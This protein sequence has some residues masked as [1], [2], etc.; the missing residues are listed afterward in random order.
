VLRPIYR[1]AGLALVAAALAGCGSDEK[2]NVPSQ[3]AYDDSQALAVESTST[4]LGADG[5]KV[6]DVSFDGPGD[7]RLTGYLVTPSRSSARH[8]AV[9]YG[10]GAGGDRQ[11]L[12]DEAM[13]MAREGAVTLTLDMIYS[14]ARAAPLPEGMAGARENSR[15][16][17]ECVQEVRRA[18]DLLQSLE[19]VDGDQIGYVGWSQGAR[20]GALISGVEHR[21]KAF[22]LIAGGAASVSELVS[23]AP[24]ELQAELTTLFEKTDPIHFV[25][26]AKPS[27]LLF[28]GGRDDDVVPRAAFDALASAGSRPKEV[29][30]YD[31]GHLPTEKMWTD[32]RTWLSDQLGLT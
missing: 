25:A 12:V 6:E 17:A 15:L 1:C 26:L 32:S 3:F 27:A 2:P 16:E 11:E 21:I 28:Q 23:F 13:N 9:I 20:M 29:R 31:A 14:P 7:T 10:H 5:V 19:S 30:R 24:T 18:V 22:D 4:A 8:P